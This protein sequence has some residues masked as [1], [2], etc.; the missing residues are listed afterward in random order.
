MDSLYQ[1]FVEDALTRTFTLNERQ[2][3]VAVGLI[4]S[5]I[6]KSASFEDIQTQRRWEVFLPDLQ[7]MLRGTAVT[8]KDGS[9]SVEVTGTGYNAY[10]LLKR[11]SM[12]FAPLEDLDSILITARSS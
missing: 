8:L 12:W 1:S 5:H 2:R 4:R 11:G 10:V 9:F 7:A 3:D 6:E